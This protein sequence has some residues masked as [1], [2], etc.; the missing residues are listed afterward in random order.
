MILSPDL[1]NMQAI[2]E[3]QEQSAYSN[4][5]PVADSSWPV[6]NTAINNTGQDD[7]GL[8]GINLDFQ[9]S[10]MMKQE[11]E[12]LFFP[13]ASTTTASAAF[14]SFQ[15][16]APPPSS[17]TDFSAY[18]PDPFPG[19]THLASRSQ[20]AHDSLKRPA[21]HGTGSSPHRG[22]PGKR[23]THQ[24]ARAYIQESQTSLAQAVHMTRPLWAPPRH[25]AHGHALDAHKIGARF[26]VVEASYPICN[27]FVAQWRDRAG[28]RRRRR[29]QQ[30]Q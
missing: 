28:R 18:P 11:I 13:C 3:Q 15:S 29:R 9:K 21:S 7:T 20:D 27:P 2:P 17:F 30:Q 1:E 19:T 6:F 5:H 22:A 26:I 24:D 10:L 8:L 14:G 12:A 23:P 16:A 25:S 4:L